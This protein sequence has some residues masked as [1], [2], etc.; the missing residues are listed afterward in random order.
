MLPATDQGLNAETGDWIQT[1]TPHFLIRYHPEE[2]SLSDLQCQLSRAYERVS[3][4]LG[5]QLSGK[6]AVIVCRNY[7]DLWLATMRRPR[8]LLSVR[9]DT[10]VCLSPTKWTETWDRIYRRPYRSR[11]EDENSL[12]YLLTHELCHIFCYRLWGEQILS[13]RWFLEG[14]ADCVAGRGRRFANVLS[15][16]ERLGLFFSD[17]EKLNRAFEWVATGSDQWDQTWIAYA[18]SW[19]MITSLMEGEGKEKMSLFFQKAQ[20]GEASFERLF[21]QV[22]RL[23]PKELLQ[24]WLSHQIGSPPPGAEEAV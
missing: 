21:H 12:V 17:L 9:D 15:E 7:R 3:H 20:A 11:D 19:A 18:Q 16:A 1:E 22:F 13:Y 24:N 6:I 10:L 2:E 4:F 23:T 14:L 5:C 8:S